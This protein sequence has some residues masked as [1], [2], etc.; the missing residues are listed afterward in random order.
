MRK[1]QNKVKKDSALRQRIGELKRNGVVVNLFG[2]V[3]MIWSL[4]LVFLI[5]WGLN[6]ACSDP[7]WYLGHANSF[8]TED[9]TLRNFVEAIKKFRLQIS[10]AEVGMRWV[11]YWEMTWNSV[12]FSVGCTLMKM[13]STVCFAYAIARFEFPGRKFLYAFVVLQMMLPI[14]GQTSANYSLLFK[15][16]LVDNPGYLLGQGAGHGMYFLITYSFFRNLPTEYVEAAKMDGAGPFTI[17]F[18]V[19]VPLAQSIISALAIM[20]F[21]G[22]WNDYQNVIIYLKSYPTLSSSLYYIK[23]Q[24]FNLGMQTPEYFAG[25]FISIIPVAVLFIIFNKQIMENVTIGGIKG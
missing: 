11:G 15:L 5:I 19:M 18:K 25:I 6:V 2:L 16:G 22:N 3:P 20:L 12:W 21:I 10:D 1:Q 23:S 17:F 8:F 24:A 7:N 14:Y 4:A 9:F 13:L